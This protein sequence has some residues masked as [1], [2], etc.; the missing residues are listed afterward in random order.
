[1]TYDPAPSQIRIGLLRRILR[2]ADAEAEMFASDPHLRKALEEEREIGRRIALLGRQ[3]S[4]LAI[5]LYLPVLNFSWTILWYEGILILFWISGFLQFRLSRVSRSW[6][7]VA[8]ILFDILLLTSVAT[9]PSP[10]T[11]DNL[12]TAFGLRWGNFPYFFLVLAL[13]V[14]AY[15]WRT[16]WTIGVTVAIVW[17]G[18]TALVGWFGRDVPL[19]SAHAWAA[20]HA[21]GDPDI[22]P[23][24]DLNNVQWPLRI[25]E[26]MVF[27]LVAGA[28][29]LKGW[30]SNRLLA[31]QAQLSAERANLSRYFAPT[32]V[33]ALAA[34]SADIAEART[35]DIAVM[36]VDIVG[37]TRL[38]EQMTDREV[39]ALLRRY[40][41]QIETAVF[42]NGGTLDKYLG[43]GVMATFGTPHP[44]PDDARNAMRAAEAITRAAERL[45]IR[46]GGQPLSVSVGVHFGPATVG[47]VGPPRRLEFAVIG[48]TVNVASR[49]EAATR[50]IGCRI[51]L[52]DA[53]VRAAGGPEEAAKAG[54]TRREG[55]VLRGRDAPV[56]VWVRGGGERREGGQ[57]A[58][59][60]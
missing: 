60:N 19:I 56:D 4:T 18:A 25:Q 31:R 24:M 20:A 38:A 52:S 22:A 45:D 28:L 23:F 35:R 44:G 34:G 7:V 49:L 43:D 33:D 50:E 55:L 5:A 30:R 27:V 48:D 9:L 39:L 53:L 11:P 10:Y 42:E 21:L 54:Y 47:D 59:G 32:V 3:V 13:A 46:P 57:D 16:V 37:F 12:P 26:A 17:T 14:I 58:Q 8:L 1:M 29:T 2:T 51:V 40:Y 6:A 36:F 41:A 15:S